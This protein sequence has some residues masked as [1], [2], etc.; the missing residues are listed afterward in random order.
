[1]MRVLITGHQGYIGSVL[2]PRLRAAGHDCV[3][4]DT[5]YFAACR[6]GEIAEIPTIRKDVRHLEAADLEGFDA[7]IHLAGLSN[8]P[9]GSLDASLT[10]DINLEASVRLARLAQRAGARRFVFASSCS[11]YGASGGEAVDETAPLAP[12]TPYA[13]AKARFE[14]ELGAMEDEVFVP[15]ILRN[16]TVHGWSPRLRGDLVVHNLLASALSTS[17]VLIKSDGTPWRPLVHVADVAGAFQASIEA[18]DST[19][20]GAVLNVGSN[21]ENYQVRDIAEVVAAVVPGS[22]VEY[23]SG[24]EPDTRDYRVDFTRIGRVLTHWAPQW[25]LER[26]VSDLYRRFQ[27]HGITLELIE[28]PTCNRLSRITSLLRSAHLDPQLHW[29]APDP[30]GEHEMP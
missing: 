30:E 2:A 17:R 25:T 21:S 14:K 13:E 3:G 6:V 8:D 28:G 5:G 16:A 7:V 22:S 23:A 10:N 24:G 26:S 29:T 4:L 12:L 27:A 15:V 18:S 20:R 1:M 11:L 9:L 19:V